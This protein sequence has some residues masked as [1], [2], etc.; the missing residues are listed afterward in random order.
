TA[1]KDTEADFPMLPRQF[2]RGKLYSSIDL[3]ELK[4]R[5]RAKI[6]NEVPWWTGDGGKTIGTVPIGADADFNRLMTR[7]LV[8]GKRYMK[9]RE[10]FDDAKKYQSP[11]GSMHIGT[12]YVGNKMFGFKTQEAA[13]DFMTLIGAYDPTVY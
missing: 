8:E 12:A 2:E 13:D 1:R 10:I 7:K 5:T 6:A 3:T 9:I 11:A 4:L